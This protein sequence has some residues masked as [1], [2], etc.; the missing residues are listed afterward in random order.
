[1]KVKFKVKVYPISQD[2]EEIY[3]GGFYDVV[4]VDF[5]EGWCQSRTIYSNGLIML[6]DKMFSRTQLDTWYLK[7][8]RDKRDK[9]SQLWCS[10]NGTDYELVELNKGDER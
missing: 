3:C 9:Q 5:V 1:M 8:N 2:G 10:V 7:D 4:R 6:T